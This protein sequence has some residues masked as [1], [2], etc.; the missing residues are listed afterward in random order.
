MRFLFLNQYFPPDP[1]PTGILLRELGDELVARG[2]EAIYVDAS[3]TY[4]SKQ[5][6][7]LRI[8]RELRGLVAMAW[9]ALSA[10]RPDV[11]IS[12]TSPPCL[13]VGAVLLAKLR[14]ARVY[15]WLMDM[16]PELAVSLGEVKPGVVSRMLSAAMGWAYRNSTVI[17]LD[18]DMAEKL[19]GYGAQAEVIAPWVLKPLLK[20]V[21]EPKFAVSTTPPAWVYSGNLGR[22]HEWKTLLEAQAILEKAGLPVVLRFQGGGGSRGPATE[23]VATLGLKQVE[24]CD[25]VP[26]EQLRGVL[27]SAGAL[28]VTQKPE[29]QGLLWPSKLALLLDLGRPILWVGP[30][31]GAVARQLSGI[32]HSGT[33]APGESLKIADWLKKTLLESPPQTVHTSDAAEIRQKSL[34]KWTQILN[35]V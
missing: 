13:H 24:W 15:H 34:Q 5:K 10:R 9:R 28:V 20:P 14:G 27:L 25:Y 21:G 16:Y 17:A 30:A 2:Q 32:P 19:R 11:I 7:R 26:E 33:F 4:R 23:Y 31:D 8:V 12:A 35:L 22:A 1:A 18:E 29:V 3:Q 6:D